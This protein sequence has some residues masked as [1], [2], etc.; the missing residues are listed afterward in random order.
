VTAEVFGC[1]KLWFN[2]PHHP[3]SNLLLYRE[4]VGKLA[5]VAF[6]PHVIADDREVAG[7]AMSLDEVSLRT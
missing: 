7:P 2:C 3:L 5:I 1:V 4:K 6:G